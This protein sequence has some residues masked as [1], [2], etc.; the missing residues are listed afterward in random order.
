MKPGI[1]LQQALRDL[2]RIG[3]QMQPQEPELGTAHGE[4]LRD[5]RA[6]GVASYRQGLLML[7]CA[8]GAVLLIA[9]ANVGGL[10]LAR[11]VTRQGELAMRATLGGSP[12]RLVRELLME[13]VLLAG[14]GGLLGLGFAFAV[15]KVIVAFKPVDAA[16][17]ALF[18]NVQ[19]DGSVLLVT[20]ALSA[21]TVVLC[22]LWPAWKASRPDLR[23]VL[24]AGARGGS[25]DRGSLR[26]REGLLIVQ[27][28]LTVVLLTGAGLLLKSLAH[29]QAANLGFDPRGVLTAKLELSAYLPDT[30]KAR[31]F[32]ER[33]LARVAAVP[34]VQSVALA[35]SAP[36]YPHTETP[37]AIEGK[38]QTLPAMVEVVDGAP[39]PQ[40]ALHGQSLGQ[41]SF[42]QKN[43]VTDG[44]FRTL[45]IPLLRGRAFGPQD[46][47]DGQLAVII[48][49]TS[50]E[51]LWPGRDPIG[52]RLYFNRAGGPPSIVVGVVPTVRTQ[53]YAVQ[54]D[55]MQAYQSARPYPAPIS[56]L[57]V[58]TDRDPAALAGSLRRAVLEVD[59]NQPLYD[60][61]PLE[62]R[63]GDTLWTARLYSF[64]LAV[65]SLLALL[66]AAIG[67][68]GALA[69]QVAGSTR[70]FGI[71]MALGSL[72]GHVLGLVMKRGI[73]IFAVGAI[74]GVAGAWFLG[75]M[76]DALLYETRAFDPLI[77]LGVV[78]VTALVT[79]AASYLPARR[80][81]RVDPM[82]A[83][84]TE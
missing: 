69:F 31:V 27:V 34:G 50:A 29:A 78:A 18:E 75:R 66:L 59:P 6:N 45:G 24:Q 3:A 11:A 20:F 57:L 30:R 73:R 43:F 60:L 71:R 39:Y 82:V 62:D 7:L 61:S 65:F 32:T 83:L 25:A 1:T 14:A 12:A 15:R 33:V 28:A 40:Q 70:E 38:Q 47:P 55:L 26:A 72:R 37:Y 46:V 58:R 5:M 63:V 17:A 8:V 48:D 35:G 81:T 42:A 36:F 13:S 19:V 77:V 41:Q 51:Q 21:L 54:P 49:Q 2:K 64:L 16:A 9:C 84:R 80:A 4:T 79:A 44:Y 68:Y 52:Q 23:A 67:L 76:F 10:L 74:A 53:G 56:R 22:G